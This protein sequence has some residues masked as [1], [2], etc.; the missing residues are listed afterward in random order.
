M[1]HLE[2]VCERKER[3]RCPVGLTGNVMEEPIHNSRQISVRQENTCTECSAQN[4]I[5]CELNPTLQTQAFKESSR[6]VNIAVV[7]AF[8]DE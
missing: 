4:P 3:H 8:D 1:A 6:T 7:S 5:F 2:Y